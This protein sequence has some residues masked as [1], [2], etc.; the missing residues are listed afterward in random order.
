MGLSMGAA[1]KGLLSH[2]WFPKLDFL[3]CY[4]QLKQHFI[5]VRASIYQARRPIAT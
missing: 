4:N 3:I 2:Y 1:D 5:L